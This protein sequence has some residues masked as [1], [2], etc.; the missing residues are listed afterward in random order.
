MTTA[1]TDDEAAI[2]LATQLAAAVRDFRQGAEAYR[3][4]STTD[5]SS[6]AEANATAQSHSPTWIAVICVVA[7]LVWGLGKDGDKSDT[8][9]SLQAQINRQ[10]IEISDLRGEIRSLRA[11]D[12]DLRGTDNA[13]RAYINTGILKPKTKDTKQ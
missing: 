3:I 12:E 1:I 9:T 6:K 13:I 10:Q 4:A 2:T 8:L 7:A 11:T 5:N